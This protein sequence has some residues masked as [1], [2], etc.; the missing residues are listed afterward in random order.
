MCQSCQPSTTCNR[1]AGM[2][3][4]RTFRTTRRWGSRSTGC[5]TRSWVHRWPT[6]RRS[7]TVRWPS[8]SPM[9][10]LSG[11]QPVGQGSQSHSP[12]L[13]M[14][15]TALFQ[16]QA[17][18]GSKTDTP[19][20]RFDPSVPAVFQ[21][22]SWQCSACSTA[23]VLRS[24]GFPDTQNDVVSGLAG[25]ISPDVGLHYGDGRDLVTLLLGRGLSAQRGP[26]QT[27]DQAAAI[28]GRKPLAM[29]S[30]S[31]Y[32]WVAVRG[33]DG[34][35]LLLANPDNGYYRGVG[36]TLSRNQFATFAPFAGVWVD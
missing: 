34:D 24:L 23:W 35:T 28:A 29:G 11:R 7:T 33:V 30:G 8:R 6:R 17:A 22:G 26:L 36:Q 10:W 3:S 20:L 14:G 18:F 12:G 5:S 32:H 13:V 25:A 1:F 15:A 19:R 21:T 27:F 2:P 16:Q 4:T 31:M 9:A